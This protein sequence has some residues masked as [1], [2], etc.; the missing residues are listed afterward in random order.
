MTI[1]LDDDLADGA[2]GDPNGTTFD[3]IIVTAGARGTSPK[4]GGSSS[5]SAAASSS[6]C[7]CTAAD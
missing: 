6:R 7:G 2:L 5:P 4:P 3:R 1:E